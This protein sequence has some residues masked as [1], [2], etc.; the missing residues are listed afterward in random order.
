MNRS[1]QYATDHPDEARA[2]IPTFTKIPTPVAEK[3]RLPLWPTGIDRAQ[4][5]EL[6][7]YTQKYG[8]IEDTFPVD[9]MIWEG[10]PAT[11]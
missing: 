4:L 6:I 7:G 11:T 1:S 10:A 3:I 2:I 8:I 9:E 5:E